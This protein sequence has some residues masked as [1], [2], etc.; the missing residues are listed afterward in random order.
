LLASLVAVAWAAGPARA[1]EPKLSDLKTELDELKKQFNEMKA[2]QKQVADVILGRNEGIRPEDAG[3]QK[4]LDSLAESVRKLDER[5]T[6]IGDRF[7]PMPRVVGSSP[8]AAGPV[9]A[10]GTVRL[11]NNYVTDVSVVVNGV[12]HVLAPGQAADVAV[13]PGE[14]RYA[15]PQSGGFETRS[16]IRDGETVT[17]R[18]R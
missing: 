10:R 7:A 11:L 12:A 1:Q 9:M 4:R 8:L 15:L 6:T 3:L 13:A 14:F 18:I 16:R 2:V 5:V 17:L